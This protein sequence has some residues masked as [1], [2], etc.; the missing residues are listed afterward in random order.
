M[1]GIDLLFAFFLLVGYGRCPRQGLRQKEANKAKKQINGIQS[2]K[3][4]ESERRRSKP[5]QKIKEI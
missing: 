1:D 5:I 4:K 3:T 2:N